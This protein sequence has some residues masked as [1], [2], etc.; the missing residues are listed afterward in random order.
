MVLRLTCLALFLTAAAG[1][2]GAAS[3]VN[4]EWEGTYTC[5]G[6]QTGL[7]LK[8]TDAGALKVDARFIFY[9]TAKPIGITFGE[10]MMD[11]TFNPQTGVLDLKAGGWIKR[12]I[13]YVTVD[14]QG[15]IGSDGST[16]TGKV[17]YPGC[18][19][20]TAIKIP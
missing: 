18:T 10:F 13:N 6:S 16:M 20:F 9:P 11:G 7:R 3:I 2:V 12:P 8:L 17:V 14:L 4:G 5:L 1:G 15:A 19:E